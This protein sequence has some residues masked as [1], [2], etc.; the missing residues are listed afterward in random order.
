MTSA[1]AAAAAAAVTLS[2]QNVRHIFKALPLP[3]AT[4]F[5]LSSHRK[6]KLVNTHV[7]LALESNRQRC[8]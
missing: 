4:A 3:A 7:T 6:K 5:S 8:L 1:A 2:L